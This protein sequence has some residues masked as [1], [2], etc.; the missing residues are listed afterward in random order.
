[1]NCDTNSPESSGLFCIA[2][3]L[4]VEICQDLGGIGVGLDFRHDMLYDAAL[5]DE[6]CAAH[7][8]H[9]D[10]AVE[11]FLLPCAVG[12]DD[13]VLCVGEKNERQLILLRKFQM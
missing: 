6:I 8:A 10:L 13:G 1:M 3:G 12:L 4:S 11:L 5:I 2:S 9:A 7:S